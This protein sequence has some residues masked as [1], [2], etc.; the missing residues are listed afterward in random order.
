MMKKAMVLAAGLGTRM[1]PLTDTLPKPLV[2]V[3][4]RTMLDHNLDKL[5]KA[6][7]ETAIVNVHYL[8]EQIISHLA[9]REK[10]SITLSDEREA[11]LDSGGGILNVLPTFG[12]EPF[13]TLNADTIWIDGPRQNLERMASM[14]DPESMDVLLLLA[15]A[16][17][18][19]GWGNKGDFLLGQDGRVRRPEK[20][21]VAP[22]AY[23]GVAILKPQSFAGKPKVFSLNTIF[24]EAAA[25][26]RLFGLRLDGVFMHIG[27]VEALHEAERALTYY[28]R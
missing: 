1:R 15:P 21:E 7:V 17:T 22:F 16:V 24:D 8:G 28:E 25:A 5:E 3:G 2:R 13:F 20:G 14:F 23:T 9:G 12:A 19:I 4:G 11:L 18:S 26:E 6:G 27:T 10:P